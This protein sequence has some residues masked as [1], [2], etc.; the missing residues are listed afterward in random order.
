MRKKREKNKIKL[1]IIGSELE[2]TDFKCIFA[3]KKRKIN[4][5][6]SARVGVTRE[7]EKE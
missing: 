1:K 4:L 6:A 7:K 3:K 5:M 2:C